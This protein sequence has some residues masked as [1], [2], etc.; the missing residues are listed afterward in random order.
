MGLTAAFSPGIRPEV[1]GQ[2]SKVAQEWMQVENNAPQVA[3]V[4]PQVV[5]QCSFVSHTLLQVG[6]VA[7]AAATVELTASRSA[8]VHAVCFLNNLFTSDVLRFCCK[9]QNDRN[10]AGGFGSSEMP[11]PYQG[12]LYQVMNRTNRIT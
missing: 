7:S 10:T 5:M 6:I 3:H 11:D 12:N 9:P 2:S 4:S 1:A 8:A